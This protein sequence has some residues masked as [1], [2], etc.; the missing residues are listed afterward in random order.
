VL[1]ATPLATLSVTE[2]A[3]A[4]VQD[5]PDE[6]K[7]QPVGSEKFDAQCIDPAG[8]S[9]PHAGH[10]SHADAPAFE[11]DAPYLPFEQFVLQASEEVIPLEF[12][13]FPFSQA[14]QTEAEVSPQ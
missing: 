10:S 3:H 5:A 7:I 2:Y 11:S 14:T 4:E 8:V 12:P 6:P 13:Y 9:L 1:H